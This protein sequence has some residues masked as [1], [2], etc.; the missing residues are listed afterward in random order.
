MH[1]LVF[2]KQIPDINR[3]EFDATTMRVK[4]DGVP[5]LMNSFDR[6]AVEEAVRIREK[7]GAKT[8]VM[9]MGPPSAR[10]VLIESLRI[11]IDR[12]VLITDIELAGA[13]TLVTSEVLA[14]AARKMSPDM[15]LTGKYSLDGET[16]QV[17]PEVAEFLNFQFKSSVSRIDFV[18][19]GKIVVEQEREDGTAEYT[20]T[21][22]A[23]ISVSEKINRARPP[24]PASDDIEQRITTI[25]RADTDSRMT[26]SDSPTTVTGT[27]RVENFR[28]PSFIEPGEDTFKLLL[29]LAYR[30]GGRASQA[31]DLQDHGEYN[32]EL[33]GVALDDQDTAAEIASKLAQLSVPERALVKIVGNISPE[34][35]KGMLCHEY[36]YVN[37]GDLESFAD[38]LCGLMVSSKPRCVVLPSS[39][40][41]RD[42]AGTV[43]ARLKLG[44]TADCI[45]LKV[46]SGR[47][48]Q[49]KPAFG[50]GIVARITSRTTPEMATVRPGI[51]ARISGKAAMRISVV[52]A[53]GRSGPQRLSFTERPKEY[54]K[55]SSSDIILGI[56]RGLK[57]RQ[58]VPAVLSLA[59]K[60]HAS[61]GATR[62]VVDMGW[63][64]RQQQIG[65]TGT[66]ISPSLYIALGISGQDNHVVGIRYAGTVVAVNIRRDAPIFRHSD[67]GI[68]CDVMDFVG[69]FADFIDKRA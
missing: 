10:E 12:A 65:L 8:T 11:G 23:V 33:W 61:V 2:V 63:V 51:F 40:D 59:E 19:P 5:L 3:I 39:V 27:E 34:K 25:R 16:S 38:T 46:E 36:V 48:I 24:G 45:D 21:L 69:Q 9:S 14:E 35:L 67:Y 20:L 13:D 28:N 60:M 17:P 1:V 58:N 7:T 6:K 47:L 4:R 41:G 31:M 56:G 32:G 37:G 55:L 50:G 62:P 18:E 42:V 54:R 52:S 22:P 49:Y 64:P 26:G 44:L 68:V 43:A 29:D 57:N 53:S 15:I 66:S 30:T